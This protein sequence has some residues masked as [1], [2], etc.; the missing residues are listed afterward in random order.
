MAIHDPIGAAWLVRQFNLNLMQT[1]PIESG[2]AS[3]RK[4]EITPNNKR[5]FYQEKQRPQATI[6]AH[7]QFHL[8]HEIVHFEFLARL[9]AKLDRQ[10]IQEWIDQEPT[11]QYARR[12]AFLYEFFTDNQ[13]IAPDNLKGNYVDAV[14]SQDLLTASPEYI[15]KNTK[16]RI[17]NNLAGNRHFCPTIIKNE[18]MLQASHINVREHLQHLNDEVG[19]DMMLRSAKWFTLGESKSS[20]QIEREDHDLNRIE[21]FAQV[22]IDYTGKLIY[23][24]NFE[25]LQKAILGDKSAVQQYGLRQSPVFVGHTRGFQ[26]IVDYI[27]P[28]HETLRDKLHGIERF[29]QKTIGQSPMIRAAAI[30]FAFVYLHPLAD[31]NGRVHRFL[32][33]EILRSDGAT[34]EPIILPISGVIARD[35]REKVA[36]AQILEVISKPL[37]DGLAGQYSFSHEETVYPDGVR[38]NFQFMGTH[39]A[40]PIWRYPDLTQHIVYFGNLLLKTLASMRQESHYLMDYDAAKTAIKNIYEMPDH[41]ID[42]IIRSIQENQGQLSGKLAKELPFLAQDHIWEKMVLAVQQAFSGSLKEKT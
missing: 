39:L 17:N 35:S 4:T 18:A 33:N 15:E 30:A 42:R 27:A 1:L 3:R 10:I 29:R 5:E 31:G 20:F 16:W 12:A 21:R 41:Y 22:M 40:E 13:L 37:M 38:S 8:R 2:I 24:L 28:P 19:E 25:I 6:I 32:F 34:Y 23:P 7:L 11:G 14:S 9:F 36:Y 26:N